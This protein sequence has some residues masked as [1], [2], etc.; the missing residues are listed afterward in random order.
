[1]AVAD[2]L[3]HEGF[4][5]FGEVWTRGERWARGAGKADRKHG[6]HA[7]HDGILSWSCVGQCTGAGFLS[8]VDGT[9]G[10]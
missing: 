4:R 5:A 6:N 1:V 7:R 10:R 9:D 3:A 8:L 2:N